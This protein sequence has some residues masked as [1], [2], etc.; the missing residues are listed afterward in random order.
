MRHIL[1]TGIATLDIVNRVEHYPAEDEELRAI[2]QQ[3]RRGGNAANTAGV[4][5]QLGEHCR[6]ACTLADDMGGDFIQQDLRRSDIDFD[7][8]LIIAGGATPTSYITQN[9]QN[10]SRTIVHYRNLP[11]LSFEQFDRFDLSGYD[12]FH[13]EGRNPQ[14][15][16]LMMEK[17]RHTGKPLSLEVEKP[18]PQLDRLLPLCNVM[19]I[20]RAFAETQGFASATECLA[21]FSERFPQT[22]ITCT[23]GDKGAW[24]IA[25]KNLFY[26]PAFPPRQ[27]VD[28]IGA[29]DTFNAGLI[30]RLNTGDR[31]E[32]ALEFACRLAG[33]KCGLQ[34]FDR[35]GVCSH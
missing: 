4:L 29:G 7:A 13:F 22:Q 24:A 28:T 17:A 9:R 12:W 5:A 10:G 25:Q 11:E 31:L 6:L 30:H 2:E 3:L 14:Q 16:G 8:S 35:L 20:S 27:I 1:V 21:H 33:K 34:G 26:S 23:W 18:R 32:R 15:T 19:M